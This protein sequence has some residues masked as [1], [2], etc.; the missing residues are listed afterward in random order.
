MSCLFLLDHTYGVP[1]TSWNLFFFSTCNAPL[2]I[3]NVSFFNAFENLSYLRD[4]GAFN[5]N[6]IVCP[7]PYGYQTFYYFNRISY[8]FI[9][10][11]I[12][13]HFRKSNILIVLYQSEGGL[14]YIRKYL[15]PF[16]Y[17]ITFNKIL[18]AVL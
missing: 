7:V 15:F 6:F 4:Y 1:T 14:F 8:C 18:P 5:G 16:V 12:N 17:L 11:I 2:W 9:E 10:I 13:V 3:F